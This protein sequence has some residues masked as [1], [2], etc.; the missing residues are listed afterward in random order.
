MAASPRTRRRLGEP[1]GGAVSATDT[2]PYGW[3]PLVVLFLVGLVDRIEASLLQGTL[4][5]IQAEWGFSDTVGG[6]IPTAAALA[7]A[8]VAIPAGYMTDRYSRTRIIAIVVFCWALTTVGS[9]LAIGF[10][11]FYAMRVLLASAEQVDNPAANSLLADYYPPAN[12]PKVYGWTRMT[13]YL[14]GIGTIFAG[15]LGELVGWRATFVI[16]AIP[17]VVVAVICWRLAEPAR[18][19]LDSVIARS[20]GA[21]RTPAPAEPAAEEAAATLGPAEQ[22]PGPP[23]GESPR[24]GATPPPADSAADSGGAATATAPPF[25]RQLRQVMAV[26][27][28]MLLSVGLMLLTAGLLGT[29]YWM[30]TYITRAYEVGTAVAGPLSGGS[31][32]IGVVAGTLA[33]AW[34]GRRAHD[35]VRGGRVTVAAAG[36]VLGAL[37]LVAALLTESLALFGIL[38]LL[39]SFLGALAI[40]CVMASVADVVGAHSRGLGFAVLNFLLTLGAALGPLAV[41]IASDASGS[42]RTAFLILTVPKLLGGVCMLLCRWSFDRDA[43]KVLAE[44]RE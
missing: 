12:R 43:E 13:T 36:T 16:M 3:A 34:L 20:G 9:G 23:L 35:A 17:G 25:G 15:V 10:A 37:A 40:P 14:G 32:V 24:T 4:P 44:A 29:A 42:L 8:L 41:G 27:T 30:T 26:P 6:S 31:S 5:L 33:G 11:M 22:P 19:Y 39:S 21:K 7:S 28:L 38:L 2:A 18:G 1:R